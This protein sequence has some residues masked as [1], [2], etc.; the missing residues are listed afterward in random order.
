MN[1]KITTTSA[2]AAAQQQLLLLGNAWIA[3]VFRREYLQILFSIEDNIAPIC[4]AKQS[5]REES[6]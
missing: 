4:N 1:D 5:N 3:V 6:D 2:A